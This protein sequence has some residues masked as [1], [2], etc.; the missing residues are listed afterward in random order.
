MGPLNLGC[1]RYLSRFGVATQ[2]VIQVGPTEINIGQDRGHICFTKF[3][4]H[5]ASVFVAILQVKA[6]KKATLVQVLFFGQ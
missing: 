2:D 4:Y 5:T 3:Y 6:T 1:M